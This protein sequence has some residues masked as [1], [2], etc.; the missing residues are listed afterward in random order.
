M[1]SLISLIIFILSIW[2]NLS[3]IKAQSALDDSSNNPEELEIKISCNKTEFIQ[4]QLIDVLV[5]MKNNRNTIIKLN[6]PDQYIFSVR[7]SQTYSYRP[8]STDLAYLIIPPYQ[9]YC[10]L[11]NPLQF[12]NHKNADKGPLPDLPWYYWPEGEY[13]YY[14]TYKIGS[15]TVTFNSNKIKIL[16][17]TLPDSLIKAFEDLKSFYPYSQYEPN[18]D[19]ILFENYKNNFYEKEYYH[20]ML[21]GKHYSNSQTLSSNRELDKSKVVELYKEFILKYPN[22]NDAYFL[23][24]NIYSLRDRG[25][26]NYLQEIINSLKYNNSADILLQVLHCQKKYWLEDLDKYG[27]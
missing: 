9:E 15:T 11:I 26:E 5:N 22:T 21:I 17:K 2:F 13:E 8:S 18:R 4:G 14:I 1:K 25:N 10:Y 3:K 7:D 6:S 24:T 27:F 19:E 12:I 23:L 16:I 20:K